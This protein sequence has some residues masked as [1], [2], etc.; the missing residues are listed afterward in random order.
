MLDVGLPFKQGVFAYLSV[1]FSEPRLSVWTTSRMST[2]TNDIDV[3]LVDYFAVA[4]Y[5]P[6]IGLVVIYIWS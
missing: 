4:G 1:S 5:D 3:T 6:D 2:N